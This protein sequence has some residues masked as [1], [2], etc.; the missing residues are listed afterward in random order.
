MSL[1]LAFVW[2]G[3]EYAWTSQVIIGLF[4][5]TG[6]FLVLFIFIEER[7]REPMLPLG[8]FR[9]RALSVSSAVTFLV[10]FGMFGAVAFLPLY[11]QS[12]VGFPPPT[13]AWR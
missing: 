7:A 4:V 1:L 9:G 11:A 6:V 13:P 2:G 5:A 12:V 3:S 8:L 10:S